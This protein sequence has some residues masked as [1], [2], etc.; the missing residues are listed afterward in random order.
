MPLWV[1]LAGRGPLGTNARC[2]LMTYVDVDGAEVVAS[3]SLWLGS[4][5]L[6]ALVALVASWP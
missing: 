6:V 4:A 5:A 3:M 2:G 1:M